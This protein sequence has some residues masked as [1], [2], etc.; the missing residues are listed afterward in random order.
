MAKKATAIQT[1][2]SGVATPVKKT[3][4]RAEIPAEVQSMV[5]EAK[6]LA[7]EAKVKSKETVKEARKLG[8]VV[9]LIGTLSE[10]SLDQLGAAIERRRAVLA[11]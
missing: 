11:P 7:D 6:R 8:K 4:M 1:E 10:W 3:R 2:I 9:T 5:D